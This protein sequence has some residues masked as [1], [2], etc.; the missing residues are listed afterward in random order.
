MSSVDTARKEVIADGRHVGYDYLVLATGAR[1]AYFG[2]DDWALFAPGL[3]TID[4]ATYLRRRILLA[5]ERA[6]NETDAEERRRLTTFV[7]IG[8]G[9]TGVEMAGAIAE[10]AHA[11]LARDFRRIRPNSARIVLCEGGPSLL[12]GFPDKLSAYARHHL[13]DLGVEVKTGAQVETVDRDGVVAGGERIFAANVLWAAGTAATPVAAWVGA[14]TGKAVQV[15]RLSGIYGPGR[16]PIVKL[17]DGRSQRIVKAGQ[18]FN[19][20]NNRSIQ[21]LAKAYHEEDE[22]N[23]T[24]QVRTWVAQLE[25]VL[26]GDRADFSKEAEEGWE[27]PPRAKSQL[28]T[29]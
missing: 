8:G 3:K 12:A 21:E 13:E 9:P 20:Y 23:Y 29:P 17:R 7:V 15:F 22:A 5:F 11:T 10:L 18:V 27:S 25:A 28:E 19:R 26:K 4:D 1:H 24:A 2:H 16:N 14:E 6:E